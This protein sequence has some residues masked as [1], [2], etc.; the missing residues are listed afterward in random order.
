MSQLWLIFTP[1]VQSEQGKVIDQCWCPYI[2]N[3]FICGPKIFFLIVLGDLLS[4]LNICGRTSHRIYRLT[5][6][7][8]FP[9]TLSSSN[10]SR[11]F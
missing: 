3:V 5:L 7:L 1:P 2:L 9:E 4:F 6:P 10:K 8:L 11:I